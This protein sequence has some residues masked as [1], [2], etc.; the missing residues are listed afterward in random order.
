MS[1]SVNNTDSDLSG[2]T[3]IT[4][5]NNYTVTGLWSFNR[6]AG[7]P[8]AV[9]SGS[10]KVTN[11]NADQVDGFDF[12]QD[13]RTTA[14]PTFV[15]ITLTVGTIKLP[16]NAPLQGEKAAIGTGE[17]DLIRVNTSDTVELDPNGVGVETFGALTVDGTLQVHDQASMS[18]V[19][20]SSG[21]EY[22]AA[23]DGFVVCIIDGSSGDGIATGKSDNTAHP[24]TERAKVSVSSVTHAFDSI[25]FPVKSGDHYS[26]I[27]TTNSGSI[28]NVMYWVPMGTVG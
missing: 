19:A 10:A 20:K 9:N 25:M 27:I 14:S 11:L 17:I 28:T 16:N 12:N 5:E 3:L 23:T 21:T 18:W 4:G 15:G 7:V 22:L 6:S 13:L 1:I 26:V 24:T 8:F 2:K